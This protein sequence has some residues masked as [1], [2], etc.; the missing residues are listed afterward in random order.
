MTIGEELRKIRKDKG[1][2][3]LKVA[4]EVGYLNR[5]T[6]SEWENDKSKVPAEK[7]D[8]Y[9]NALSISTKV[10]RGIL[11]S[12]DFS[13]E[14][15]AWRNRVI[16][17]DLDE[18]LRFLLMCLPIVSDKA[19]GIVAVTPKELADRL[20]L[21]PERIKQDW[22]KLMSTVFVTPIGSP[23]MGVLKLNY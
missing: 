6:V 10:L 8:L 4:L 5:T 19:T 14:I 18:G 16:Q 7:V 21:D 23:E 17:A 13:K 2:S 12:S 20:N 1:L 9:A 3:Q 22:P 15:E 11:S